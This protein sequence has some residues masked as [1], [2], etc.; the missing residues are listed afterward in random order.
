MFRSK[1][2]CLTIIARGEIACWSFLSYGDIRDIVW[3]SSWYLTIGFIAGDNLLYVG[4]CLSSVN[5][6]SRSWPMSTKCND[7]G[8]WAQV[9]WGLF[10]INH[11]FGDLLTVYQYLVGGLEHGFYEFPYIG[12]NHPNWPIFCSGVETTNQV[13]FLSKSFNVFFCRRAKPSILRVLF[14]TE[15]LSGWW[16]QTFLHYSPFHGMSSFPLTNSSYFSGWLVCTTNQ[17]S[18]WHPMDRSPFRISSVCG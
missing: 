8:L 1:L 6:E 14:Y 13:L 7:R 11:G 3:Y 5:W 12:D 9:G 2:S 4:N 18:R 15:W 17:L 10:S 16:F